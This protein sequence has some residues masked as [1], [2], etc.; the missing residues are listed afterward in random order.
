MSRDRLK[1]HW[2]HAHNIPLRRFHCEPAARHVKTIE[3]ILEHFLTHPYGCYREAQQGDFQVDCPCTPKE[4]YRK[5]QKWYDLDAQTTVPRPCIPHTFLD[6][7]IGEEP[8]ALEL[9]HK[10]NQWAIV[11][12]VKRVPWEKG[13][14]TVKKAAHGAWVWICFQTKRLYTKLQ[15]I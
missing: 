8:R 1:T 14:R 2:C 3:N 11:P 6:T 9:A 4:K 12:Y 13:W 5:A 10:R 7:E 15:K